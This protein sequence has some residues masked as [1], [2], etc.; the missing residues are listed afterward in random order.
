MNRVF[1][2]GL[3]QL[4]SNILQRLHHP[5]LPSDAFFEIFFRRKS[6]MPDAP[7]GGCDAWIAPRCFDSGQTNLLLLPHLGGKGG[8]ALNVVEAQEDLGYLSHQN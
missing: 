5:T 1:K 2:A 6:S 8:G 7:I 4:P 3:L